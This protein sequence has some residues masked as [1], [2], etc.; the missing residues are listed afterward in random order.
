MANKEDVKNDLLFMGFVQVLLP[1]LLSFFFA[2]STLHWLQSKDLTFEYIWPHSLPPFLQAIIMML[3]ADF[4]RYWLHILH[5][6]WDFLWR[7]HSIHHSPHKLYWI[8]VG[9]FHP[10][11]KTLQLLLD[12]LP[13]I[14]L[15][16]GAEVL[17]L[18]FIFYAI[19][20]FFQH[21]NIELKL[22]YLN[23]IISGPELHRWHH[24]M[25]VRESNK[26]YGNNLIIWDLIFGTWYLPKDTKV[27]E[28]G[29]KN[30]NYPLDFVNQ[31]SSPFTDS[32]DEE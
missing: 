5:H 14:I 19:N 22:G 4:L 26:N 29:L 17:S 16:V 23:Y 30:R 25:V 32:K 20:G 6:R 21:S 11:E 1:I 2:I 9:R 3:A 27:D 10:I 24:S 15:G 7:F 8:N 18:Y 12:T 28:L 13:F 31:L